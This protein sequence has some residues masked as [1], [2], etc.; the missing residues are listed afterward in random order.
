MAHTQ[1]DTG[2]AK[3]ALSPLEERKHQLTIQRLE[4]CRD[5]I[6]QIDSAQKDSWKIIIDE[7]LGGGFEISELETELAASSNTIYKW[8]M[9]LTAPREMTRRL[10]HRAILEMVEER[11]KQ[12]RE[13]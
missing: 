13:N 7:L 3:L 2:D 5:A 11:L 4:L 8:R 10:L 9:G 12:A 6:T 1:T